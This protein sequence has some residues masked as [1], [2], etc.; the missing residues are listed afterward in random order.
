MQ[1]KGDIMAR[2][3]SRMGFET[4]AESIDRNSF[5]PAYVQ[6]V[7]ILKRQITSGELRVGDRLPSESQ[8]CKLYQVSPMT[9]R[10]AIN[11]LS[12]QGLVATAQGR[13]TFVKP[14]KLE[15]ASFHLLEL[16]EIFN[17]DR[18]KVS[19]LEARIVSADQRAAQKLKVTEDE[20]IIYIRRLLSRDDEP[21]LYHREYLIYDP[22]RAVVESELGVTS[23]RGL[24]KG[25]ETSDF[26][27]GDLSIETTVINDDEASLLQAD[28]GTAAFNLEHIFYDYND[29]PVSWGWFI[30][31][32]D[33]LRF[34]STIGYRNREVLA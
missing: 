15:S 27:Y 10:R 28:E 30:C 24:F 16:Q 3:N 34:T 22:G 7:Y 2:E 23:L 18:T 17:D 13:G 1:Q 25:D 5:E 33:R 31:R 21:L 11:I 32:G 4:S 26:K 8:I 19:I 6:L 9:V 14:I 12:D 29:K 20:R